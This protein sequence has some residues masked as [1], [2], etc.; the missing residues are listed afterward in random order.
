MRGLSQLINREFAAREFEDCKYLN[1]EMDLGDPGLRR[2]KKRYHPSHMVRKFAVGLR[3]DG[4]L[5]L[6]FE[7]AYSHNKELS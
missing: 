7:Y 4:A 1:R 3:G 2:A 6:H 5:D